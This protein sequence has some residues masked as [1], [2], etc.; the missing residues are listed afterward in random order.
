MVKKSNIKVNNDIKF[1]EKLIIILKFL[2]QII[3]IILFESR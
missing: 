2:I 1:A 3:H